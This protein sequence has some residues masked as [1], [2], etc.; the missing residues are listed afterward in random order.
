MKMTNKYFMKYIFLIALLTISTA[1][2]AQ[3]EKS[4]LKI[5]YVEGQGY[6]LNVYDLSPEMMQFMNERGLLGGGPSW[7]VLLETALKAESPST[8]KLVE[9]DDESDDVQVRSKSKD[10]I[11]YVQ[12]IARRLMTE[13]TYLIKYIEL[14]KKSGHLE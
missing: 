14:A 2:L 11:I 13:R 12:K 4:D 10:S 9:L 8:L 1:I 6:Y 7:V 5:T 3:D